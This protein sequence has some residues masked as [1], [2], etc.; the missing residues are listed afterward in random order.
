MIVIMY[1]VRRILYLLL[2]QFAVY[3]VHVFEIGEHSFN[4][5]MLNTCSKKGGGGITFKLEQKRNSSLPPK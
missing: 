1:G 2:F 5:K 4:L 3:P